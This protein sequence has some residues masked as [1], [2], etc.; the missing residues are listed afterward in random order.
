MVQE[1][2]QEGFLIESSSQMLSDFK[3]YLE[4]GGSVFAVKGNMR[5]V[6]IYLLSN[7]QVGIREVGVGKLADRKSVWTDLKHVILG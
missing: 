2:S 3:H 1:F 7:N 5:G 4:L 6:G